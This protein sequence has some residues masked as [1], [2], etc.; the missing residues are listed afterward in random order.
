MIP[1]MWEKDKPKMQIS[2]PKGR[3]LFFFRY[4]GGCGRQGSKQY[5]KRPYQICLNADERTFARTEVVSI[6]PTNI[7]RTVGDI[8]EMRKY[9][10]ELG[11]RWSKCWLRFFRYNIC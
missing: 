5:K 1:N 8:K 10:S 3:Y 6:I 2:S 4:N 7:S 11:R 9:E